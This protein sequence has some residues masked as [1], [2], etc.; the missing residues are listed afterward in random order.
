MKPVTLFSMLGEGESTKMYKQSVIYE[1]L[2]ELHG[3][4]WHYATHEAIQAQHKRIVAKRGKMQQWW[5]NNKWL[6]ILGKKIFV[7]KE[8]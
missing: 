4:H 2:I 5:E 3:V 7:L 1:L 8:H 6:V